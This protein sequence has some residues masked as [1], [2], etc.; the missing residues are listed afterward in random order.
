MTVLAVP[1]LRPGAM[2]S[3]TS[4]TAATSRAAVAAGL[5]NLLHPLSDLQVL[6]IWPTGDFRTTTAVDAAHLRPAR[7]GSRCRRRRARRLDPA[8]SRG[9]RALRRR[10]RRRSAHR[11]RARR[12]RSRLAVARRQGACHRFARVRDLRRRRRCRPPRGEGP[13]AD[14]G[15]CRRLRNRGRC[16]LVE[17]PRLRERVARPEI[18]A[19]RAGDDRQDLRRRRADPD[20]GVPALRCT[21]L[22]AS[23]RSRRR[24]RAACTPGA[25]PDRRRAREGRLGGHRRVRTRLCARLPH[26]R[27]AHLTGL[28]PPSVGVPAG[29]GGAL[30]RGLAASRSRADDHRASL[31]RNTERARRGARV[32]RGDKARRRCRNGSRFA[33]RLGASSGRGR[34]ALGRGPAPDLDARPRRDRCS[35]RCWCDVRP[36]HCACRARLRRVARRHASGTRSRS[37]STPGRS[38]REQAQFSETGQAV[39]FGSVTLSKGLARLHDLLRTRPA[40]AR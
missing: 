24:V 27:P 9:A 11:R 19:H 22:P 1:A 30:L 17:R 13:V 14:R 40:P 4:P 29:L 5:G 26:A 12:A 7:R 34:A 36:S 10:G 31:A 23:A 6:G 33:S 38:V 39:P 21:P 18:A 37:R 35:T 16:A 25:A 15:R 8:A 3:S 20:D 32:Q 2:H 28:E